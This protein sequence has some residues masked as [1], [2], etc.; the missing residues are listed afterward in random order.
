MFIAGGPM[1][2]A[3]NESAGDSYNACAHHD[4]ELGAK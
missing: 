4:G 1:N 2:A 3:T